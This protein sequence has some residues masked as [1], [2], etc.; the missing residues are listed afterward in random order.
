[1]ECNLDRSRMLEYFPHVKQ[2]I[3]WKK[4]YFV[5]WKSKKGPLRV[6]RKQQACLEMAAGLFMLPTKISQP[7]REINNG[8]SEWIDSSLY[9]G[10]QTLLSFCM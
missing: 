4:H 1:M 10:F 6:Q 2:L 3:I 8:V 7:F 5:G 9:N